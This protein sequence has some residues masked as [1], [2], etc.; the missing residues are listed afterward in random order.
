MQGSWGSSGLGWG[1]P[2]GARLGQA[3]KPG[4]ERAPGSGRQSVCPP[5]SPA[6]P[7]EPAD[8]M[9]TS[10][11]IQPSLCVLEGVLWLQGTLPSEALSSSQGRRRTLR[12]LGL[13]RPFYCEPRPPWGRKPGDWAGLIRLRL[14]HGPP[15]TRA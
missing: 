8:C 15:V 12:G 5:G 14:P 11:G 7:W 1:H 13:R 3:G 6:L 2:R 4:V 10:D 9:G